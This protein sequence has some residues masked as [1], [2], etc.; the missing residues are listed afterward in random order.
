MKNGSNKQAIWHELIG[1]IHMHTVHS[2]GTGTHQ[3]LVDAAR[4]ARLNFLIATDHNVL[5][6]GEEGWRDGV[7]LLVGQEIHDEKRSPQKNHCLIF[8]TSNDLTEHATSPQKL[9]DV[10]REQGNLAFLAHPLERPSPLLPETY[11]WVNWEVTGFSGVELWNFLSEFR[12]YAWNKPKAAATLLF[13]HLF[14]T[15]PWPEMLELWDTLLASRE[16]PVVAIGGSDAHAHMYNLGP[17][18]RLFASY[19]DS[20][21][22]VNTHILA[23][24]AFK[25]D[26]AHDR[27]LVYDALRAGHCWLG[28]D[29]AAPTTG[30]RFTA[31]RDTEMAVMG[32]TLISTG[33]TIDFE[34]ALP[35]SGDVRLLRDGKIVARANASRLRFSTN[36]PGIYRVEVWRPFGGKPRGWIFSNPIYVRHG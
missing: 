7:L 31:Q 19:K 14:T 5:V 9:L 6:S 33:K 1:N 10:A 15:G 2:D 18:R 16:T 22:A 26:L 36:R 29:L 32:D 11:D 24:D 28:Y 21:R 27:A 25:N 20:F 13:P 30:F 4:A 12:F 35:R 17:F 8:G 23:P 34:V 3:D